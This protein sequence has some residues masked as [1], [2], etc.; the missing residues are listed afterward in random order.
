MSLEPRRERLPPGNGAS[1]SRS[2]DDIRRRGVD[3]AEEAMACRKILLGV[4][5]WGV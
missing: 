1:A 3:G 2:R 5:V 4:G